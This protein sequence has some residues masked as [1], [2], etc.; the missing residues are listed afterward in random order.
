MYKVLKMQMIEE[1]AQLVIR[2]MRRWHPVRLR[3]G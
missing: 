3:T 2:V 1:C